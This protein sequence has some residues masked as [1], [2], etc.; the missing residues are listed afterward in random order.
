VEV[1]A[2]LKKAKV[3]GEASVPDDD[4]EPTTEEGKTLIEPNGVE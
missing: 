2:A 3:R 4:K 1:D